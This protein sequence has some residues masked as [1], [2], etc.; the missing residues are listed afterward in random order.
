MYKHALNLFQSVCNIS[1]KTVNKLH[2]S[3]VVKN[4]LVKGASVSIKRTITQ[5]DIDTFA[6][7]SGDTN[8]IHLDKQ[9]AQSHPKKFERCVVH[10]ILM[11]GLVSGVVGTVLPGPGTLLVGKTINCP[12][13]AYSGETVTVCVTVEEVRKLITLS[14]ECSVDRFNEK[15]DAFDKVVVLH[16]LVKVVKHKV[17]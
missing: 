17:V 4:D 11:S 14:Y 7:I 3:C 15:A 13:P 5:Q 12:A 8:A 16:G 9:A 6:S 2:T 10:G 1:G